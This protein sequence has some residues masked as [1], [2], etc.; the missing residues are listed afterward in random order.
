MLEE[1]IDVT[2]LFLNNL[3]PTTKALW[4]KKRDDAG[5]LLFF[6]LAGH[7]LDTKNV[8]NWLYNNWLAAGQR[9]LIE[10]ALGVEEAQKLIKFVGG[11]HDIG[12]AT[13]VFQT[14]T[15]FDHNFELDDQ[16]EQKLLEVGFSD[17]NYQKL[18]NPGR[19][20]HGLAGEA[21]LERAGVPAS[22]GALIGGHHG[23]PADSIPRRQIMDYTANYWQDD[24]ESQNQ[25]LWQQSE[26]ELLAWGLKLAGYSS[27]KEIPN[28]AQPVAVIV[29]GLLIMADWLA[30]SEYLGNQVDQPLFPLIAIDEEIEAIDFTSRFQQAIQRWHNVDEWS[31]EKVAL[32]PDPYCE[33]WGFTARPIQT[34]ITEA[35]GHARDPG[36]V[37]IEAPMG[38]GKTEIALVAAEQ[39][40]YQ[41]GMRG[42]FFGLPSQATANSMFDRIK[43]WLS[44]LTP[45]SDET[46]SIHL[47]H[48]RAQFN[49]SYQEVPRA[50]MNEHEETVAV[51]EWFSGKKTI[52]DEFTVGTVDNLLLMAL[53]Q[54]HLALKHLGL[55]GKVVI[56]D[57]VHAYDAYMSQY[58]FRAI[59]W[60]GA[61]HVPVVILSATL[62]I[63]KRIELMT[64]YLKGKNGRKYRLPTDAATNQW[65]TNQAYPLVTILDGDR[66]QQLADLNQQITK[67]TE[68]AFSFI[69]SDAQAVVND[70][71]A[72]INA[73]GV[74]GIIVNT[75][76]RAQEIAQ[77]IPAQ[78]PTLLLHSAFLAPDR[79]RLEERLQDLIGKDGKRPEKMIVI[80]SQVLEQSLDIDFDILYSDIAPVDLL[81]QRSGRLHRHE[82]KRPVN[83]SHPRLKIMGVEDEQNFGAANEAIY[84]KFLLM[85][86]YYYLTRD[87]LAKSGV[88]TLPDDISPLVQWV[89]DS[90]STPAQDD[91][92]AAQDKFKKE[93]D[94]KIEK[95]KT[96][97][98][99]EPQYGRRSTLH[100]WLANQQK[101]V[102][103]NEQ[104]A[105]ASVRDIQET[106]EVILIRRTKA[107]NYLLDGRQVADCSDKEIAQQVIRLPLAVSRKINAAIAALE[108]ETSRYFSSW[109]QSTWLK[110]ALALPLDENNSCQFMDYRLTYSVKYG[111]SYQKEDEYDE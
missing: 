82:I 110:G 20:P 31:P 57:E 49:Q 30:S 89:Y 27:V 6:P 24:T 73:G 64:A 59:E 39:L 3:S 56:I 105:V 95:A 36:I 44:E 33:R 38:I 99:D 32:E 13:F 40:A 18:T 85:K 86:T 53:K 75:V 19:S 65:Q 55:S 29:E 25:K 92:T 91:F 8:I 67:K 107:G 83:V 81:L 11:V 54:K 1:V 103:T 60:L 87:D 26:Q 5:K 61:Y 12:K 100:S 14:K 88:I 72:E 97:R 46:H 41:R 22:V 77:L 84:S 80:G 93:I 98:V 42:I 15:G 51:D 79:A 16:I 63:A 78:V 70:V 10:S 90:K 37:I 43:I 45:D 9:Q 71:L 106:L 28:I 2:D 34:Q 62:P 102:D 94:L 66:V 48:G 108:Q 96:F 52:L 74:A 50:L 17:L 35:I 104:L 7:L 47:M 21:I 23:K 4:A 76:K 101:Q 68:I 69:E 111:L 58:L 109:Q